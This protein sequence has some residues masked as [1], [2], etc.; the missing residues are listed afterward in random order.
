LQTRWKVIDSRPFASKP[1]TPG[2]IWK[3]KGNIAD[4]QLLLVS[5]RF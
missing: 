2:Y 5:N 4:Q 3:T 1:I